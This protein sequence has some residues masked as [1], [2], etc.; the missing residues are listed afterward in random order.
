M[1]GGYGNNNGPRINLS[2]LKKESEPRR[3]KNGE[4]FFLLLSF[5]RR[6]R[7]ERPKATPASIP[8][9]GR[10]GKR[11]ENSVKKLRWKWK[12]VFFA[13]ERARPRRKMTLEG[14]K[15]RQTAFSSSSSS[16]SLISRIQS[17]PL[18]KREQE[19][20]RSKA[21]FLCWGHASPSP[22]LPRT[23]SLHL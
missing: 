10:K 1:E 3:E 20:E 17:L 14:G 18:R 8:P 5:S 23:Q 16:S 19:G 11:K 4:A 22:S 12:K 15:E 21:R 13:I 2:S 7:Y 6:G 9:Q